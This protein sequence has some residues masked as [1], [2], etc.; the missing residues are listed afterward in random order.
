MFKRVDFTLH[1]VYNGAE[2]RTKLYI[3]A[4]LLTDICVFE[5][6]LVNLPRF[7]GYL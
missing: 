3:Y 6:S 2:I 7:S 5:T 1:F 4:F